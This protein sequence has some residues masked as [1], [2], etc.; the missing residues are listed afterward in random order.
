MDLTPS[1]IRRPTFVNSVGAIWWRNIKVW[2]AHFWPSMASSF[3]NPLLF[4]FAF[5]FGLGAVID[6]MGNNT[7]LVYVLPGIVANAAF[8]NS[9]FEGSIAAFSRFH[10]QKTYSA[11]LAAPVSLMEILIAEVLWAA[12]KAILS[13]VAVLVVG[14]GVNGILHPSMILMVI[15]YVFICCLAFA[16]FAL[17]I[18]S[19]AKGYEFF[20]YFFTFWVSP[21]FLFC[22]VFFEVDRF[23]EWVQY[24]SWFIPMTHM[25]H[26]IRPMLV[27]PETLAASTVL[28]YTAYVM[29]FG[30]VS[31]LLAHRQLSKRLFDK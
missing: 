17:L 22:G 20:N 9:S 15:P 3:V 21:A 12:T 2:L 11:I 31:L 8:F 25:I 29:V 24:I 23:P 4:L 10:L 7:Y 19:Y 27:E 28:L 13:A 14:L 30:L 1:A 26:V 16:A 6:N 5:G 18:M